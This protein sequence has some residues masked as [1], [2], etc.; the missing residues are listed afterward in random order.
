MNQKATV[1]NWL[2]SGL[3]E[4]VLN[5]PPTVYPPREDSSLLDQVIAEM[6]SGQ[7]KRLLEIGCGSGAITIAAAKR[8][9][10]VNACDINPL[11]VAATRGNAAANGFDLDMQIKEG[12]PGYF[13]QWMPE[14][15]VDVIAWNLPYIE[16]DPRNSLGPMEDS[17][18]IG[19]H[20]STHLLQ[21][22]QSNPTLLNEEGVILFLHSSNQIGE[23]IG[24]EWRRNGWATRN[25]CH[26]VIGDE[27]L[28]VIACWRPFE[29]ASS[30]RLP[31]CQSTNDEIFSLGMIQQGTFVSTDQQ[32]SGRGYSGREWF[33]S[34]EGLMGSWAL[35]VNSINQSPE[36][37]QMAATIAI[38]DSLSATLDW[39]LPS[40]SW[41]HVAR[42][43]EIG[44]RVKWP[45][46]IWLRQEDAFGKLCGVLVE[47]KTQGENV[48]LVLGIGMNRKPIAN[49]DQ[50][51]GW[52]TLTPYSFEELLPII[53][54]SISSLL[55][56][57]PRVA[58]LNKEDVLNTI[59][60]AMRCGLSEGRPTAYGLDDNG[61]LR[62]KNGLVTSTHD[63]D[64][65]W[66]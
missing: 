5:I 60:A 13:G 40:H 63:I 7:N 23:A 4:I 1:A 31:T 18:L 46:D 22:I 24:S 29:G 62:T 41:S 55:E 42:L 48:Q 65:V 50:T 54:A 25:V 56:V 61:G 35:S 36:F 26:K 52:A 32:V 59:Y 15:G 57:H 34:T 39:G 2:A 17:A 28:T 37:I 19:D 20:Q 3:G 16:P 64:W 9:W 45:N 58:E 53:H 66:D 43:E 8:G 21:A 11:A 10:N 12:G 33:N 49:L 51:A 6:G 38:L 30:K 44:V 47:G 14:E 27:R